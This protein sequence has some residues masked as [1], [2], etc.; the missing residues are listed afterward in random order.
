MSASSIHVTRTTE[1]SPAH[2]AQFRAI[3]EASFPPAE[4]E[5]FE[6][7]APRLAAG[8]RWFF[9]AFRADALIGFA[10]FAPNIMPAIHLLEF[11]AVASDARSGG[12]GGQLLDAATRA[13]DADFLLEVES[14]DECADDERALRQHRIRFYQ[15]HG[16]QIVTELNYRIPRTDGVGALP[17]K[18]MWL[19]PHGH[20]MPRGAQLRE[21][22]QAIYSQC[23]ALPREHP[24]RQSG[25]P[26]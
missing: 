9:G 20:P 25:F 13:L 22:V 6:L 3:Y 11:L 16:A 5:N 24:L 14:D 17:M 4:R 1:L 2:R 15:R 18:L 12:I 19:S 26:D 21:C 7:Y 23:Y 10:T 8:S